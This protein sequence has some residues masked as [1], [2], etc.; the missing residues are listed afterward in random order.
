MEQETLPL[1]QKRYRFDAFTAHCA[2]IIR[3]EIE[4]RKLSA[5]HLMDMKVI[6]HRNKFKERLKKGEWTA[7]ELR[8]LIE[9]L[10]IDMVRVITSFLSSNPQSA[11]NNG[12]Y[13]NFSGFITALVQA[14]DGHGVETLPSM[15]PMRE[16]VLA[17]VANRV[18]DQLRKHNQM[19][20]RARDTSPP[21]HEMATH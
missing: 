13:D 14:Y 19:V 2:G 9:Y 8:S 3:I 18:L 6:S 12:V 17:T 4:R 21:P 15:E 5:R 20:T 7:D 11:Y 1:S 10:K 16:A